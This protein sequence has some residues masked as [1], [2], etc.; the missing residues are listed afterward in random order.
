M[1]FVFTR[2]LSSHAFSLLQIA[3]LHFD[4]QEISKELLELSSSLTSMG[5]YPHPSSPNYWQMEIQLVQA[6]KASG[7]PI[8]QAYSD[9]ALIK[10]LL[11]DCTLQLPRA[12]AFVQDALAAAF[13]Q[14]LPHTVL[15]SCRIKNAKR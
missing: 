7:L 2:I 3:E 10:E 6:R 5:H 4:V 11:A 14:Q 13:A 15:R 9:V 8:W 1:R 12:N